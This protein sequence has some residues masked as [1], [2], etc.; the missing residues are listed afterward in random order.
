MVKGAGK[1]GLLYQTSLQPIWSFGG[2]LLGTN[3]HKGKMGSHG[4]HQWE[5]S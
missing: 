4:L 5:V 1:T 2:H 3:L